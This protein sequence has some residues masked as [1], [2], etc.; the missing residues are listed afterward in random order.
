[1]LEANRD[2]KVDVAYA[3]MQRVDNGELLSRVLPQF[4]TLN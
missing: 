3:L 2:R 4:K 1:M